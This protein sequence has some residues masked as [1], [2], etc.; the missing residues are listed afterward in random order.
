MD[1][2]AR[3]ELLSSVHPILPTPI[4]N[5]VGVGFVTVGWGGNGRTARSMLNGARRECISGPPDGA[6][7]GGIS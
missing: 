6:I 1:G 4:P 2:T 3:S 7:T 5:G